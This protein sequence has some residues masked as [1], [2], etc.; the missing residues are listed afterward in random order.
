MLDS[1]RNTGDLSDET[2]TLMEQ[3]IE[4]F[5]ANFVTASGGTLVNEAPAEAL[6]EADVDNTRITRVKG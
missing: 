5:K 6:D 3:A 1:I 2:V 4:A